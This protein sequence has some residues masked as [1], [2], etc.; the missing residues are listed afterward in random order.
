[1][2]R[3]HPLADGHGHTGRLIH[4]Y[5]CLQAGFP[6]SLI[7][8]AVRDTCLQAK[9]NRATSIFRYQPGNQDNRQ[10]RRS[11][12][13]SSLSCDVETL[14]WGGVVEGPIAAFPDQ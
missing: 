13:P 9:A 12:N 1:M 8:L 4:P 7:P 14:P 5:R 10:K 3:I 2:R 11:G 6:V